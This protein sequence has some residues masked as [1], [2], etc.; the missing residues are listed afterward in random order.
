VKVKACIW[1]LCPSCEA[2][3]K[4]P[5]PDGWSYTVESRRSGIHRVTPH[6]PGCVDGFEKV[7]L[8]DGDG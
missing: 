1:C 3:I 8:P 2:P 6:L 5:L 4:R 7:E